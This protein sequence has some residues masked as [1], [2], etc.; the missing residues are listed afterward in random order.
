MIPRSIAVGVGKGGVGK[1]SISTN[2]A[3]MWARTHGE[4]VLFVDCDLQANATEAFGLKAHSDHGW[5]FLQAA[6]HPEHPPLDP[7]SNRVNLEVVTGGTWTHE[8]SNEI[9]VIF[10]TDKAKAIEIISRPFLD[11]HYDVAIIDLPPTGQNPLAETIISAA[12]ALLVPTGIKTSE[13]TGV[14]VLA[15]QLEEEEISVPILG[16]VLNAV[17][18]RHRRSFVNAVKTL[19]DALGHEVHIFDQVIPEATAAF[20]IAYEEQLLIDG[21]ADWAKKITVSQRKQLSKEGRL[22]PPANT[23]KL[24]LALASLTDQVRQRFQA[25]LNGH[26]AS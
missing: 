22:G 20:N 14:P 3:A 15:R 4:K 19:D 7:V 23:A 5:N 12:T 21:M 6:L 10:Q 9:S 8:L 11:V 26:S 17:P 24:Y 13:L 16:V 18:Q 25:V 1:T 2:I